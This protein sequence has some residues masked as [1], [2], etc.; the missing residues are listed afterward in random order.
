MPALTDKNSPPGM[1]IGLKLGWLSGRDLIDW[2]VESLADDKP[3]SASGQILEIGSLN[4]NKPESPERA[5]RLISDYMA[6]HHPGFDEDSPEA[7]PLVYGWTI[8][9][10]RDHL[11]GPRPAEDL[12]NLVGVVE[13]VLDYPDW[14]R[15]LWE[16]CD[17][18]VFM[19]ETKD[20]ARLQGI[21]SNI[22]IKLE[23]GKLP[24]T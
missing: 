9:A 5:V 13:Q 17:D 19:D 18:A 6:A 11:N 7:E 3:F 8:R 15:E 1:L 2:A 4:P 16:A 22:L 10:L 14:C 24:R 21:A 23:A 12:L 20:W